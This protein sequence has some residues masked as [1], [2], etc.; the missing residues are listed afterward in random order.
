MS[1]D[2]I[3]NALRDAELI[4]RDET[5]AL[6]ALTGGVSSDIWKVETAR[7][8]VCVKRALSKLKTKKTWHAPVERNASEAEWIRTVAAIAPDAV[9]RILA[10]DRNA[11]LF[12]MEYFEPA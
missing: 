3:M 12:V 11:G 1:T 5:P 10:E 7:G 8:P 6:E 4:V 2:A 9:P